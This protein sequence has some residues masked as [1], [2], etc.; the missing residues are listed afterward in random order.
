MYIDCFEKSEVF[1]L[2]EG[3]M[4]PFI[5]SYAGKHET[6]KLINSLPENDHNM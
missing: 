4:V 3:T 5:K 2:I 1:A 6:L